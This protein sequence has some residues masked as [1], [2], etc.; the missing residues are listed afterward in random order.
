[1]LQ[2][3][4]GKVG[5]GDRIEDGR[6]EGGHHLIKLEKAILKLCTKIF[7]VLSANLFTDVI[8]CVLVD[9]GKF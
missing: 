2:L 3:V 1:M 5:I 6:G 7:H 8:P 4:D 9:L